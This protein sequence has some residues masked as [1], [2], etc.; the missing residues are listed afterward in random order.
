MAYVRT[1]LGCWPRAVLL[2][3]GQGAL[4]VLLY[5]IIQSE[6]YALLMGSSLC[7]AVLAA[8]MMFTRQIDW[9]ALADTQR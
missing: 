8:V 2:C 1:I 3:G 7:F 9:Y 4:Y 5:V 6:D